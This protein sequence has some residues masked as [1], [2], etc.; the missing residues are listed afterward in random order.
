MKPESM[1]I[2]DAEKTRDTLLAEGVITMFANCSDREVYLRRRKQKFSWKLRIWKGMFSVT[3]K[4]CGVIGS[5]PVSKEVSAIFMNMGLEVHRCDNTAKGK[6]LDWIMENCDYIA[7]CDPLEGIS[8]RYVKEKNLNGIREGSI[9]VVL[10]NEAVEEQTLI[11]YLNG[12]KII[13]G[14]LN[15]TVNGTYGHELCKLPNVIGTR[16]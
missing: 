11:N 7:I 3:E 13:A 16:I 5:G 9:I 12:K 4:V 2:V 6:P 15:P 1:G 8:A 10:D 14:I